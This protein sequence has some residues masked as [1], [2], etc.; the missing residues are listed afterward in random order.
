VLTQFKRVPK[1]L[2]LGL[3][4]AIGIVVGV[5]PGTGGEGSQREIAGIENK[6]DWWNFS[7][8]FLYG[9]WPATFG[10][11]Q[12]TLT[13][14]QLSCYTIGIC[15]FYV[16]L[17]SNRHKILFLIPAIIG[18]YF[19]IQLWRDASLL[20]FSVLALSLVA[21]LR[22]KA[23]TK[24]VLRLVVSLTLLI[25]GSLFKPIFAPV[26]FLVFF[27][28]IFGQFKTKLSKFIA[29]FCILLS[30]IIPFF[31]D[32][33][34]SMMSGLNKSYPE[35][36]VYIYDISKMYCWGSSPS[37]INK[38]KAALE[39]LMTSEDSSE[40]IC[41]SLSPTGWDSLRV[42]AQEVKASPA[43]RTLS[44]NE[45]SELATLRSN[46]ISLI[47]Q[48]PMEWLLVKVSDFAQVLTMAN[49]FHMP[50]IF[51]NPSG[52][53]FVLLGDFLLKVLLIP[54]QILDKFRLLSMG[55]ALLIGFVLLYWNKQRS[56]LSQYRQSIILSFILINSLTVSL[57]TLAFIANNGRYVMPYL[58]V[59]YLYLIWG[60]GSKKVL[61]L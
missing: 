26:L 1:P 55:A 54:I 11:W 56:G 49:A 21:D 35:Q 17:T 8:A 24:R 6:F 29:L 10:N 33:Q 42:S 44:E 34:L 2:F 20:S 47:V 9:Y 4:L 53:L 27:L 13:I 28:M 32:R 48:S 3:L 31:L 38:S 5:Y 7:T 41:A 50:G 36:Q 22:A 45:V 19:V 18:G 23:R 40:A 16:S 43:L 12:F 39:P 60:I 57:A 14:F 37:V 30:S 61:R 46:W 59:S 51:Q 25:L 58:L 52:N 15:L